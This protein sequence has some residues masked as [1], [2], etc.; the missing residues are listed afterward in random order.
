MKIVCQSEVKSHVVKVFGFDS[1]LSIKL[2]K[3]S[4]FR[5]CFMNF[6]FVLMPRTHS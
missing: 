2:K 4:H 5:T 3:T 1:T 6:F